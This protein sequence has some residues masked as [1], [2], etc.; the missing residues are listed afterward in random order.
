MLPNGGSD[1]VHQSEPMG[2]ELLKVRV[3][4]MPKKIVVQRVAMF[5]HTKY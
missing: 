2:L 5:N 3:L 4:F 1:S